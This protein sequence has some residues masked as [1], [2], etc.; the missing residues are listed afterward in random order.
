MDILLYFAVIPAVSIAAGV[1]AFYFAYREWW[2]APLVTGVLYVGIYAVAAQ[3]FAMA[4]GNPFLI[5]VCALAALI[6]WFFNPSE[7]VE[8]EEDEMMAFS[9]KWRKS[10]GDES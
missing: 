3:S 4:I 6:V 9:K 7:P 8:E 2:I 1:L 10:E 5:P